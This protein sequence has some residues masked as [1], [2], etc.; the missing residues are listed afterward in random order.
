ML[1]RKS[2]SCGFSFF[3]L[4]S[5]FFFIKEKR[6]K[7]K[8]PH[9]GKAEIKNNPTLERGREEN[10]KSVVRYASSDAATHQPNFVVKDNKG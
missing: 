10:L 5:F 1:K 2:L 3:L 9:A 6:S 7:K 4:T 8:I